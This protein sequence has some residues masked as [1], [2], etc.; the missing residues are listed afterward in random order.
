M[1][2]R[3]NRRAVRRAASASVT[4]CES[5][6]HTWR[7]RCECGSSCP[8]ADAQARHIDVDAGIAIPV[9]LRNHVGIVRMGHR[10]DHAERAAILAACHVEEFPAR[11]ED[12]LIV[13]VDLIGASARSRLRDGAPCCD[14]SSADARSESNQ[15]SSRSPPDRC[16]WSG[17]PRTHAADPRRRNAFCRSAPFDIRHGANNV[18]KSAPAQEILPH[19]RTRRWPIPAAPTGTKSARA[20]TAGC[21]SK[22]IRKPLRPR[23][24]HRYAESW[25][26]GFRRREARA[27]SADRP[28]KSKNSVAPA[29]DSPAAHV[30][31]AAGQ[32]FSVINT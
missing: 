8:G 25:R 30:T 7:R 24:A 5:S 9:A 3:R 31:D 13:E 19:C 28:S 27:R 15:A 6:P 2:P 26:R 4:G 14:T 17:A 18:R 16:R 12:H 29:R 1:K 23:P 32:C 22:T 10:G 11:L 20:H 21:C